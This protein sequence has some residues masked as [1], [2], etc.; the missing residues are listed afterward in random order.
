MTFELREEEDAALVPETVRRGIRGAD[1]PDVGARDHEPLVLSLRNASGEIVGG[2][3]G[4]TM[5]SWLMIDGLWVDETLRGQGHGRRLLLRG[6]SVAVARGCRGAWLGT[7]D[8]QARDFY[9]RLG[10]SVFAT[11]P[12]F[13]AGH[14]HFHLRKQL[15]SSPPRSAGA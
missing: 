3:Y 1:P 15:A 4:A 11:L 6:E 7:F 13:P 10:Y 14:T 9:E 12:G 2:L 8:F 5:W